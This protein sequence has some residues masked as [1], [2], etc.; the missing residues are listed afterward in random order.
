MAQVFRPEQIFA[1]KFGTTVVLIFGVAG[2]ALWRILID[3]SPPIESPVAQIPP[4]RHRPGDLGAGRR[5]P[6]RQ[7]AGDPSGCAAAPALS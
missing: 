1:L 7:R 4:Y 3:E 6:L 2:I 5:H